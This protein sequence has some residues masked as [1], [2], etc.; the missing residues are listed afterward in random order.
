MLR[1]KNM[2]AVTRP[3]AV[4]LVALFCFH[5]SVNVSVAGET[6]E[7]SEIDRR[8]AELLAGMT[9]TEKI[10]QMTQVNASEGT[11]PDELHEALKSGKIG[12]ILNQVNVELVNEMQRIAIE[13]SRLGIPLLMGRDVIHGFKTILPIPLGQAHMG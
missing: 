6:S 1:G 10:G 7:M 2:Q 12:S 3:H 11:I 5:L 8:V 9:V 4:L 13:E